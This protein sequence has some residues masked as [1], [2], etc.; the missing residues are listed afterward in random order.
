[1]KRRPRQRRPQ[2]S[3]RLKIIGAVQIRTRFD[4]AC[5][6]VDLVVFDMQNL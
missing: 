4:P 3:G 6:A 1:L 2:R 5:F